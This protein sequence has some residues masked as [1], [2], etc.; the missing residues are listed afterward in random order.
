MVTHSFVNGSELKLQ[1][2]GGTVQR[3][4]GGSSKADVFCPWI[5]SKYQCDLHHIS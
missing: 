5:T 1:K 2:S 4:H 3:L